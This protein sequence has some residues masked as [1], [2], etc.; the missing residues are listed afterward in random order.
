MDHHWR[1]LRKQGLLFGYRDTPRCDPG[2]VPSPTRSTLAD[3]VGLEASDVEIGTIAGR[4]KVEARR[5]FI[6]IKLLACPGA[7]GRRN[8]RRPVSCRRSSQ[9]PIRKSHP[10][11]TPS[12][13]AGRERTMDREFQD[14]LSPDTQL[15]IAAARAGT[16]MGER[17][18][19]TRCG[20]AARLGPCTP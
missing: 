9:R 4:E 8:G 16:Q 6:Y 15:S 1:P 20:S 18:R 10:L 2:R 12:N 17:T 11:K 14:G 3:I 19:L 5:R 13:G 7:S